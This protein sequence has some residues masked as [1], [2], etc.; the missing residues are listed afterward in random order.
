VVAGVVGWVP[1]ER[2]GELEAELARR[3]AHPRFCGVRH[4]IHDDPDPDW[5]RRPAVLDGLRLLA[6]RG[7]P[8][9]VVAERPRHLEHVPFLRAEVPGLR[10]VIDHLAKPP[11]ATEGWQPWADLIAAAA[12]AGAYAK[13]S[14]LNTAADHATWSA[15]DL[16]PYVEHALAC[17]GPER[18]M[19]G[20]DW[21]VALLAGDYAKVFRETGRLLAGLSP[22]DR[23]RILAGTAT[24]FYGLG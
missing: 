1:L 19:F 13:V 21:P 4:L 5:L 9:D 2:P 20:G 3:L 12:Q 24:E 18:L 7:V 22:A 14:G 23:E 11:I 10:L 16:R 15:D 8:F 17:F 6:E